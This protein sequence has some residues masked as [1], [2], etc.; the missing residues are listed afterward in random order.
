VKVGV[1]HRC[2]LASVVAGVL[3]CPLRAQA[4]DLADK[5]ARDSI[6]AL[7]LQTE[8]PLAKQPAQSAP[9][10]LELP[11]E[12]VW[13][14]LICAALLLLYTLRDSLMFWREPSEDGWGEPVAIGEANPAA[15][16]ADALGTAD[17]LSR[18]G[19]F[20]EAMHL[21]LLH[22]L[23]EIRRR[24]NMQF[25]D[26]LTSREILRAAPLSAQGRT[27]LR[28]IVAAVEWTYF[29]GYPAQL[30]D[31]AACRRSYESLHHALGGGTA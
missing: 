22:S 16:A 13:A 15:G 21:L 3:S 23:A 26:A 6:R 19:R 12:L 30:T 29:G 9:V 8:L 28:E 2:V 25:G 1:L 11:V 31:Y 10:K 18:D 24:L 17:Q 4:P 5:A 20:V 7:G 14:A 27:S